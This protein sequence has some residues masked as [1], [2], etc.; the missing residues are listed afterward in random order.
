MS[1][2]KV[3]EREVVVVAQ[4]VPVVEQD[5][6]AIA[7]ALAFLLRVKVIGQVGRQT[8]GPIALAAGVHLIAE[9]LVENFMAQRSFDDERKSDDV[10]AEQ[11]VGRHGKPG[12]EKI[13]HDGKAFERK[14]Q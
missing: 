12:R 4:V 14:R 11:R 10:L 9:P 7:P 13:F 5:L 3:L 1:G 6:L 8:F 2:S